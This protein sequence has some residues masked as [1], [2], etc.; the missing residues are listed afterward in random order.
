MSKISNGGAPV[1]LNSIDQI[2]VGKNG[3]DS[4]DINQGFL[5]V[6][7][8]DNDVTYLVSHVKLP[9]GD[10][11]PKAI[12]VDRDVDGH[13][14]WK[15]GDKEVH[16]GSS[17][18]VRVKLAIMSFFSKDYRIKHEIDVTRKIDRIRNAYAECLDKESVEEEA[19]TDPLGQEQADTDAAALLAQQQQEAADAAL[20]LQQQLE[21][22]A[23]AK[24]EII[25]NLN[26][27][28][29]EKESELNGL[30]GDLDT[31]NQNLATVNEKLDDN[32]RFVV[33]LNTNKNK[34]KQIVNILAPVFV[35][36]TDSMFISKFDGNALALFDL[37]PAVHNADLSKEDKLTALN[38][39]IKQQEEEVELLT[40]DKE[41]LSNAIEQL[42]NVDIPAKNTEITNKQNEIAQLKADLQTEEG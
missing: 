17:W 35:L 40:N 24:L 37:V 2:F 9:K 28:I 13:L 12:T 30:H 22:A 19:T 42:T 5:K 4:I 3:G 36:N 23:A 20:L 15:I 14:T 8:D 27:K 32:G 18:W 38:V 6:Y 31:L 10:K 1:Q 41:N 21:E 25:E 16:L 7:G 39:Y 26:T 11:E 34:A 29:T 33:E